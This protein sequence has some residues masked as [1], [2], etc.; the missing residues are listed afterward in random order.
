M[1]YDFDYL[2]KYIIIGDAAVGKSN[3]LLQY[4]YNKFNPEYQL[5]LGVEFGSKIIK[6]KD[7][8]YRIQIWDTAGQESFRSITRTYYKCSACAIVVYDITNKESF[9]HISQWIEECKNQ[10]SKTISLILVGNKND[11]EQERKVSIDEG[12]ELSE[13]FQIP[14]Y[15][16]SAKTGENVNNIFLETAEQIAGNIEKGI[17]D[18]EDENSGI[19]RG[20]R[21]G[22]KNDI[23]LN[24]KK[25]EKQE[26]KCCE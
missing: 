21:L 11:L 23:I 19:K 22:T 18:L 17:I 10:S 26:K 9:D 25:I 3:L 20:N 1:S 5:T 7:K 16:T 14:F 4:I 6:I 12:R 24:D 2:L 15:E 8:F 13:K